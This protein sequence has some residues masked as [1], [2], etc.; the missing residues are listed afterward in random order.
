MDKHA[1]PLTVSAQIWT[2]GQDFESLDI[3]TP[4]LAPG[5]ALAT[6]ALATVC[7]SDIHTVSGRRSGP[8]PGILGHEAVGSIVDIGEGGVRDFLGRELAAGD[9]VVWSVTV[10]CGTC[11]R[12]I[13]GMSAKCRSLLKTGHEPLD[14]TWGMSGGYASHIHLPR[15]ITL[16]SVPDTI[17]DRTAAPSAC[18]TATVMAVLEAAGPLAGRR[19]LV[20]GAGML[21]IVACA[22][23]RSRGAASVEVRD[24]NPERLELARE[25]GAT[26]TTAA[27]EETG[28]ATFD[29]A[30]ELSG[31]QPA[32]I[33]AL[34]AL[35]I[36]GRLVLAGSVSPGPAVAIVPER[37]VRSLQTITG[38]HNYEP[39]H[40][41][42]AMDFLEESQDSYDWE[43]L[44]E[45]AQ[46]MTNLA[47]MMTPP[48]GRHL[49]K[50]V[51][52]AVVLANA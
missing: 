34:A 26:L 4:E 20:S 7:G 24:L 27:G 52:S 30:V 42:Q 1:L 6:I 44:V 41:Q 16:V 33:A 29:V 49:R 19:V 8:F 32:V 25:F 13:A 45:E 18:A 15:G 17:S 38:V 31:A 28:G 3:P 50:S 40:L 43:S 36:G 14:G 12:C 39:A 35:D 10:A 46:P 5:E 51:T 11:D 22:V 9:R 37:M 48:L 23:A 47:T 21:G 2:G